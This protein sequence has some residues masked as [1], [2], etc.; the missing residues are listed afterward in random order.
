MSYIFV[1]IA[2][3]AMPLDATI[4][5]A[6]VDT[7]FI[8]GAGQNSAL[9]NDVSRVLSGSGRAIAV[10]LPGHPAG[11]ITCRSMGEYAE[12]V[13]GF[14][15]DEGLKPAICGHSM[16]GAVALALSIDHPELISA[17]ILVGTGAKLNVLPEILNGLE[18]SPLNVI[19]RTI[20]PLSFYRLDLNTAR[21]ARI[22]LSLSN[23]AVFLNDYLAC[24]KFDVRER[25]SSV[26]AKTLI[27]CGEND[28][29]TPPKWS[30]YLHANLLLSQGVFFIREAGHMVPLEKPEL[31][32]RLIQDFL[33]RLA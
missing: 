21:K 25:L 4:T 18:S 13:V 8:H 27:I 23:P 10:N 24:R 1:R 9:W 15:Q 3:S 28:A 29:M 6:P 19:E 7:I 26:L 2:A 20:T 22:A 17:L 5:S 16:G 33:A 12:A 32:G 31:C 14:I 11:A 30:H